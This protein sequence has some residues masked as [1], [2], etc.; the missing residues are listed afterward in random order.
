MPLR[1]VSWNC[2]RAFRSKLSRIA[3]LAPDIAVIQECEA[4]AIDELRSQGLSAAWIGTDPTKGLGVIAWT[5]LEIQVDDCYDD[6]NAWFLPAT[7]GTS[8]DLRLLGVWAMNHR[9]RLSGLST[10]GEACRRHHSLLA[11]G[12]ALVVGDF[13]SN[14][15]WDTPAKHAFADAVD[16]LTALG[17]TSSYHSFTGEAFGEETR[18]TYYH[19]KGLRFTHHIDFCFVPQAWSVKEVTVGDRDSWI[20]LSDHAPLIVE[21]EPPS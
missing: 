6:G 17:L 8:R 9:D 20:E 19:Q 12:D 2:N 7:V 1:V 21:T 13:N 15:I 4:A 10:V 16:L 11:G 3:A 14:A 18:K 5:G